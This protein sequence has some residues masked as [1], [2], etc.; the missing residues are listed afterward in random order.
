MLTLTPVTRR[1]ALALLLI[2][3]V[4]ALL[5][6]GEPGIV[7]FRHDEAML[8]LLA[9]D[10]AAGRTFPLTGIPSS[11]GIPNPP[12]SVYVMAL[13]YA[14]GA[15]PQAA[16]LFVAAMNVLGVGLL[17]LIAHR[18]VGRT[19]ALVAG[20]VYAASPWAVLYS[21]KLWAQDFHTPLVLLAVLL[22]LHG[23]VEGKRWA[24]V[25]CLPVLIFALQI[26]FAAWALLPVF[27]VL[28]WLGRRN[29]SLPALL[30]SIVLAVLTLVPF[31]LGLSQTLQADPNRI[32][33]ALNRNTAPLLL[34][35][36][37][38]LTTARFAT[39]LGLETVVAPEQMPDLLAQV[40]PHPALWSLVG[41]LALLG[42]IALLAI[43]A[44]R[45]FAP[46]LIA[47]VVVPLLVFSVSWT[48]VYPHYLIASIP[49]LCLLLGIGVAALLEAVPGKPCRRAGVLT[50]FAVVVLTQAVWWRG[51]L[52]Y[53]DTTATPGGFGTPIHYVYAAREALRPF[54][55]VVILTDGV[56]ILYDQEP[57]I[58]SAMLRDKRCVRALTGSGVAVFPAQP[59]AVLTAPNAPGNPVGGLYETA[60]AQL[61]PLRPGE[62]TYRLTTFDHAP[63]WDGP[64]LTPLPP[65]AFSSGIQLTGYTLDENRLYLDWRLPGHVDGDYH[66]FG[67]F[68][69]ADGE[70]IGQRDNMLW[71]GRY[72]CKGDRLIT[73]ADADIPAE[74]AVLRVGLYTLD[75]GAFVNTPVL[76]TA[77]N[78]V[79]T[80]LDI[81]LAS[82]P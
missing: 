26:H 6:L 28:L 51:L 69:N 34:T 24:Q 78:P 42:L 53:L 30:V 10:M 46:L 81:P 49:A 3:L 59:F 25:L 23:F 70:K 68:L 33:S 74:T 63:A 44:R 61:F 67:H 12:A 13:P 54:E 72:W 62:G 55:D 8:S 80:W 7:E 14:F 18:Y 21:R 76:D 35:P 48:P 29:V 38:L 45:R 64:P 20:L 36:D 15:D 11:V 19:V 56:E 39:G 4:A 27:G 73:W 60:N 41:V 43:P 52:R 9:Q 5:R 47:W 2:L 1:D 75:N 58:W 40:P 65:T 71:P 77:G 32:T 82:A 17:W 22:G 66:Y 16:T 50:A 37:A 57:A 79:G 31:L